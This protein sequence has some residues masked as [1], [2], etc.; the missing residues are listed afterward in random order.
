MTEVIVAGAL[1]LGLVAGAILLVVKGTLVKKHH[2]CPAGQWTTLI[3][4]F[5]TGYPQTFVARFTAP[6]GGP[7]TGRFREEKFLWIFPDKVREGDL[8]PEMRFDRDWINAIY[9]LKV[10]PE[11]DLDAHVE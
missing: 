10:R 1:G 5:G 3:S 6:D 4:N 9:R 11:T 7:V 2:S 8:A